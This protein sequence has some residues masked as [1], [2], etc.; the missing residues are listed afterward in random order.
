MSSSGSSKSTRRQFRRRGRRP[1]GRAGDLQNVREMVFAPY[2]D[3]A[4]AAMPGAHAVVPARLRPHSAGAQPERANLV[5]EGGRR[6]HVDESR[7]RCRSAYRR[8]VV[9][10]LLVQ[11][12]SL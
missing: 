7:R 2:R 12:S 6:H 3:R 11:V 1:H 9:G 4:A 10:E 8:I 5:G